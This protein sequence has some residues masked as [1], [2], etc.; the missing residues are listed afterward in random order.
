MFL[1]LA[2]ATK[3]Y[4]A[5]AVPVAWLLGDRSRLRGRARSPPP[6]ASP[7]WRCCRRWPTSPGFLHSAVMVQV[8]EVLRMDALSFA[9]PWPQHTGAPMPG[10]AY[11]AL[12]VGAAGLAVVARP[13][14]AGGRWPRRWRSPLFTAFAF[15]KK[16]FCNYY[17]MVLAVLVL[18]IAARRDRSPRS[19]G[20]R[21]TGCRITPA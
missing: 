17:V 20:R 1:G 16:A 18:A 4:L 6:S 3:Q 12:V 13:G 2:I 19:R 21:G 5:L 15:G 10:A 14:D 9:V 7:G 11:A 8:R